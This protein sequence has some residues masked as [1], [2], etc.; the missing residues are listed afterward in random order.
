MVQ[1]DSTDN[2]AIE[3]EYIS[4]KSELLGL[5]DYLSRESKT[6]GL[7]VF[8]NLSNRIN[9]KEVNTVKTRKIESPLLLISIKKSDL[10][11]NQGKDEFC[12]KKIKLLGS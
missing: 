3:I 7:S 9:L 1:S 12:L 6:D 4:N 8:K 11:A 5:S 2:E 10:I